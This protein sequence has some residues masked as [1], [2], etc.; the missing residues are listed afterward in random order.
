MALP[1][2]INTRESQAFID[3][4]TGKTG[5]RVA[6][7]YENV[8]NALEIK[9][10][11]ITDSITR[12][13]T[14]DNSGQFFLTHKS[15]NI[16]YIGNSAVTTSTGFPVEK[17]D[18]FQFDE[19]KSNDENEIYAICDTGISIDVYTIAGVRE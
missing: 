7:K 18:T 6:I 8:L 12:V 3:F 17:N 13:L 1:K 19:F 4:G 14:P 10:T 2:T 9:K 16:L 5:K 11:T 15:D